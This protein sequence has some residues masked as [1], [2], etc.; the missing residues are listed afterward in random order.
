LVEKAPVVVKEG[1][2][3]EE[4]EKFKAILLEAGAGV[5]LL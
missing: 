2:P 3:K 4:A 5:E 1:I